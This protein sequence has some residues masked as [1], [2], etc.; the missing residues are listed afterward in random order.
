LVPPTWRKIFTGPLRQVWDKSLKS[1]EKATR[2]IIIGF[3]IPPTDNHFKYLIAAG[4][5]K[6]I[7]LR[8][9][10]FINPDKNLIDDRC[11]NLFADITNSTSVRVIGSTLDKFVS[12]GYN[13][14]AIGDFG[15]PI[16]SS[17]QHIYL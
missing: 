3:S 7:S 17:I 8:E 12:Q 10:I 15:R 13:F 2:I 6:N 11:L 1:I 5:Q 4:L 9:I 14:G 16:P